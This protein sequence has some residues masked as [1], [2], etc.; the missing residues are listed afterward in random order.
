MVRFPSPDLLHQRRALYHSVTV[1]LSTNGYIVLNIW[2]HK[3]NHQRGSSPLIFD[4]NLIKL[5]SSK[6]LINSLCIQFSSI[7]VW[8]DPGPTWKLIP[9]VLQQYL[10]SEL[11]WFHVLTHAFVDCYCKCKHA[12]LLHNP[13][14]VWHVCARASIV[15]CIDIAMQARNIVTSFRG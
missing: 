7:D 13:L 4:V 3:T 12:V 8:K 15:A 1:P 10:I 6:Y 14:R 9:L 5:V 11:N 2:I